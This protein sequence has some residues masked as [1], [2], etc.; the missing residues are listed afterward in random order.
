MY[1]TFYTRAAWFS[2]AIIVL[3]IILQ[4]YAAVNSVTSP[5][6]EPI[7]QLNQV[8]LS[9]ATPT[10]IRSECFDS[11]SK[12]HWEVSECSSDPISICEA[13]KW[14]W[15]SNDCPISKVSS[16]KAAQ[17]FKNAHVIFIGDSMVR[18]IY[19]TFNNMVD[20]GYKQ[21]LAT[22]VKKH[23]NQQQFFPSSNT[24]VEFAWAPNLANVSQILYN[25]YP[26]QHQ[27]VVIGA[28]VWDALY[29][30]DLSAY[31]AQLKKM[32]EMGLFSRKGAVVVWMQP[33]TIID[34][35]LNTPEKQLYMKEDII[36]KY[37]AAFVDS[38]GAKFVDFT[39]DP[40]FVS[41]SREGGSSDGVHYGEEVY[42]VIAQMLT[43]GYGMK[44]PNVLAAA[45]K[46]KS[47]KGPQHTG[48]MSFPLLGLGVL[49]AST[50]MLISMDSFLGVGAFSLYLVGK[51]FDWDTAYGPL[52][53]KL[54]LN[55]PIRSSSI[56]AKQQDVE[57]LLGKSDGA[58]A[59]S[60]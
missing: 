28:A 50:V 52:H 20:P 38:L 40:T 53:T 5:V 12:G 51:T 41:T 27:L 42:R 59:E 23:I 2:G 57:P 33:T 35:R 24:S 55:A 60:L 29:D 58:G 36:A 21:N 16:T 37:R 46:K 15:D 56:A 17:L 48:S 47:A 11:L 32:A 30:R 44:K 31:S 3:G 9:T 49:G 39:I 14:L 26:D 19:H 7:T 45:P 25:M 18:N 43:R 4:A 10:A 1:Q 22:P 54:G 13:S 34:G 8:A 6:L